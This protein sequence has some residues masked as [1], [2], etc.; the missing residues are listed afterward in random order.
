MSD[1]S[2]HD[3]YVNV[4]L[5]SL[6]GVK[7]PS[8]TMLDRIES[9]ITERETAREY[10]STLLDLVEAERYPSPTLLDRIN[11]LSRMCDR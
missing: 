9:A 11:V 10:V 2:L 6:K 4:L 7:Y 3:R 8:P 1:T 5:D